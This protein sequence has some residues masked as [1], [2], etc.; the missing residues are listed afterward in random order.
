M[1]RQTPTA[2]LLDHLLPGGLEEF[3]TTRRADN[4]SWR[5]I[6]REVLDLTDVDISFESL[7]SWFAEDGGAGEAA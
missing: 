3:V 2:R 6:A 5:R 1:A 7:R 4:V